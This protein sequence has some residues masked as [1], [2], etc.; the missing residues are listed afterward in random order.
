MTLGWCLL[1]RAVMTIAWLGYVVGFS[2]IVGAFRLE[3]VFEPK[4]Q[5]DGTAFSR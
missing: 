2:V 1:I 3:Q 4:E 5:A